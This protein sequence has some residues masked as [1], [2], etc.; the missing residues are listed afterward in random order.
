[1]NLRVDDLLNNYTDVKFHSDAR[2]ANCEAD[3]IQSQGEY[4]GDVHTHPWSHNERHIGLVIHSPPGRSGP[5]PLKGNQ[6]ESPHNLSYL[7][8]KTTPRPLLKG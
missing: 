7:W 2:A 4:I 5:P 3:K 6:A 8:G 1:M